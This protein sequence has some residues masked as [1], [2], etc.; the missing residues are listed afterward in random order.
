MRL[1][2]SGASSTGKST[3]VNALLPKLTKIYGEFTIVD[4]TRKVPTSER[5]THG[6]QIKAYAQ[7]MSDVYDAQWKS[8]N[9]ISPRTIFDYVAYSKVYESWDY[10]LQ[11]LKIKEALGHVFL[12]PDLCLYIPIEF[13]QVDDGERPPDSPLRLAVDETVRTYLAAYWPEITVEVRGSVEDRVEFVMHE[14]K[15]RK[16]T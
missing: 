1:F 15:K 3:L 8:L 6:G 13:D 14:L 16:N 12:K 4:S 7:Y 11:K 5:L 10:S 9:T 2:L